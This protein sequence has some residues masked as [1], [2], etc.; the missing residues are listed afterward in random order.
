MSQQ[1]VDTVRSHFETWNTG[2]MEAHS[3]LFDPYVIAWM[4]E[5]W[6]ERGPFVG[7]DAVVHQERQMRETWDADELERISEFIALGDRVAVRFIWHGVG[8]GPESNQ[9]VTGIYTVRDGTIRG[10]EFFWNHKDALEVLGLS[11]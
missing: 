11:E 8:R 9:E 3:T 10:L 7:R 6:P 1:N 2:D 5:G 4:P